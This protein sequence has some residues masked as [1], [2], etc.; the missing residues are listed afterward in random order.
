MVAA[1]DTLG[2]GPD[3]PA[4]ATLQ[5]IL[6]AAG[7]PTD[8]RAAKVALW[9]D[10]LGVLAAMRAAL[11]ETFERDITSFIL[12]PRFAPTLSQLRPD[13]ATSAADLRQPAGQ[14]V[15]RTSP[16]DG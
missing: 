8:V 2:T 10:E 14:P 3:D 7:L 15:S 4:E 1:G 11:G 5:I 13:L 9:L 12:S 6:R 16:C